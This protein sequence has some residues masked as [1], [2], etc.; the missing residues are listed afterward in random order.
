VAEGERVTFSSTDGVEL[1]GT[2]FPPSSPSGM[3]VLVLAAT[4]VPST[5]YERFATFLADRGHA[6]LTFDYRGVGLSR[7][8]A[9]RDDR[10]DHIDWGARDTPAALAFLRERADVER[11]CVV[12]HSFGGHT[13]GLTDEL[14]AARALAL[15]SVGSAYWRHFGLRMW[16]VF[17]VLMPIVVRLFGYLPGRLGL[18][19]DLPRG[20]AL[21]WARWAR[22]PD[23][24]LGH[25]D[26]ARAR[27]AA[28]RGPV[29]SWRMTDDGNGPRAA[30]EHV[31][32]WFTGTKPE[33]V[34]RS[35]AD[36]GVASI[37]HR[38][39]FRP[40]QGGALWPEVAGWL[41]EPS[42]AGEQD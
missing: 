10:A 6:V 12:A 20:V 31:L 4:A 28:F 30:A 17:F 26:Q 27:Y 13:L 1:G 8:Q 23:Y 22:H 2:F 14:H 19:E 35:P 9:P 25:V 36:L 11:V 42:G 38:G 16:F 39:F 29:R 24:L 37:G 18:G 21:Q 15:I 33:L 41:E 34:E 5:Y 32:G 7:R 40:S 3:G